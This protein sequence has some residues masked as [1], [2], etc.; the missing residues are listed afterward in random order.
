[1]LPIAILAAAGL[2]RLADHARWW[3]RGTWSDGVAFASIVA[4]LLAQFLWYLPLVRETGEEAWAARA[5]R[6]VREEVRDPAS[7]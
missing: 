7:T 6:E 2:W 3:R 4:M 5:R 1:M